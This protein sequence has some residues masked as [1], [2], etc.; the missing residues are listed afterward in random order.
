MESSN[1]AT[2]DVGV[3]PRRL[4]AVPRGTDERCGEEGGAAL[5]SFLALLLGPRHRPHHRGPAGQGGNACGSGLGH[6]SN[7]IYTTQSRASKI[8]LKK[9]K[10][11]LKVDV[12]LLC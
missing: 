9:E 3:C 11:K 10:V 5:G 12:L 7:M 4:V 6:P 1:T 8:L 2:Y